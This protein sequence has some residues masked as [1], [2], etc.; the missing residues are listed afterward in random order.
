MKPKEK[1]LP[2]FYRNYVRILP[3]Q[4][5]VYLLDSTI[6]QFLE[7]IG[8]FDED[9]GDYAYASGK[10]TVKEVLQHLIDSERIFTYR[11]LRFSRGDQTDLPGFDQA[12]YI[13]TLN[14]S[15]RSLPELVD[16]LRHVRVSTRDFYLSLTNNQLR[17]TGTANGFPFTV[18]AIAYITAG[19]M[20]HHTAVLTEKY[21]ESPS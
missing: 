14:C 12:K 11:A 9:R 6:N 10:W 21:L 2:E 8:Q 17:E 19:H 13:D 15:K 20:A 1:D 18:N 4:P 16:E 5:I 7:T 3:D